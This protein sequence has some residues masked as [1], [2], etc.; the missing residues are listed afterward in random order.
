[1]IYKMHCHLNVRKYSFSERVVDEWNN[2]LNKAVDTNSVNGFKNQIDPI[3]RKRGG[4]YISQHRLLAPV[5][6]QPTV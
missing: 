4:L 2:L 1:M 5:V 3:L 6:R